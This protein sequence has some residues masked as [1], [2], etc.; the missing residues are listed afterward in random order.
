MPFTPPRV[1]T[2]I[3]VSA[4]ANGCNNAEINIPIC[5]SFN[6]EVSY[7]KRMGISG[8]PF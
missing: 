5:N 3:S 7:C 2:N 6:A 1:K 8:I 4:R